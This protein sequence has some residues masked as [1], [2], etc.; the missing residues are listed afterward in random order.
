M[1]CWVLALDVEGVGL[2]L[3]S[4]LSGVARKFR[5][6]VTLRGRFAASR[7]VDLAALRELIIDLRYPA[8]VELDSPLAI[9]SDL[10]WLECLPGSRGYAELTNIH[11]VLNARLSVSGLI[12]A[13]LTPGDQAGDGY[14]PHLTLSW[15]SSPPR[16]PE[17]SG[18]IM[19]R[20]KGFSAYSY[21]RSPELD[22]VTRYP[23]CSSIA[24]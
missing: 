1:T 24:C 4:L 22:A 12:G 21:E 9:T 14:R 15:H 10:T 8:L 17:L 5:P 19:V 13:D 6:H 7:Q 2:D 3:G 20:A 16:D 11:Q 18:S 23:I